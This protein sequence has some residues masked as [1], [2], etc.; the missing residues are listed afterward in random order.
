MKLMKKEMWDAPI[1]KAYSR[2]NDQVS[3]QLYWQVH[4]LVGMFP[5]IERERWHIEDEI[6]G[7]RR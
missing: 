4:L 6:K 7:E 3:H 1:T 2:V 5:V